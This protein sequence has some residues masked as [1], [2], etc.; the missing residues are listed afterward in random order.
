M[1]EQDTYEAEVGEWEDT[2]AEQISQLVWNFMAFNNT[3][4][5]Q[6][7]T[8]HH[9]ATNLTNHLQKTPTENLLH[10]HLLSTV[11]DIKEQ[12]NDYVSGSSVIRVENV[13]RKI[14]GIK[15]QMAEICL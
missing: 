1:I 5:E 13:E 7:V 12:E 9:C 3:F 14:S 15:K 6:I 8:N 2:S 10:Y 11:F 4:V